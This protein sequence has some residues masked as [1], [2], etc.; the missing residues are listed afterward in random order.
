MPGKGHW[1]VRTSEPAAR[2]DLS[3][4]RNEVTAAE[5]KVAALEAEK[6]SLEAALATGY[7]VEAGTRLASVISELAEAE[8]RWFAAQE[9][10]AAQG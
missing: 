6:K 5:R 7:Q 1:Q 10:L 8:T 2:R 4:L 9:R 3:R